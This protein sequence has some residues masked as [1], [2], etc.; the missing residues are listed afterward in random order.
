[1]DFVDEN[2]AVDESVEY[3]TGLPLVYL[4]RLDTGL[5]DLRGIHVWREKHPED[6]SEELPSTAGANDA[7][8]EFLVPYRRAEEPTVSNAG[9]LVLRPE[10]VTPLYW[11]ISEYIAPKTAGAAFTD[12]QVS[13]VTREFF[14]A[15]EDWVKPM[16]SRTGNSEEDIIR[17]ADYSTA[18][19]MLMLCV[20]HFHGVPLESLRYSVE[21]REVTGEEVAKIIDDAFYEDLRVALHG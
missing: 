17:N 2:G 16:I 3:V 20:S 14:G 9:T 19:E 1:M 6:A 15:T 5:F 18:A 13:L 12:E 8:E 4:Q 21:Q 7:E 10:A 11:L